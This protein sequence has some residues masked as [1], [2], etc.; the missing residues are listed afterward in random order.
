[1]FG[2]PIVINKKIEAAKLLSGAF[3]FIIATLFLVSFANTAFAQGSTQGSSNTLTGE[4]VAI[5][6]VHNTKMMT[7]RSD[8][9]GQ[10][11]NDTLTIMLDQNTKVNACNTGNSPD[12]IDVSH[13]A[14]VTYHE[15]AGVAVADSIDEEC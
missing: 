5:D 14:T 1:M 9:I 4:V 10:F 8:D 12:D 6:N 2:K 7:L 11:P 15:Q 13:N 3:A